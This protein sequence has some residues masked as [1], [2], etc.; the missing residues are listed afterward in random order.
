MGRGLHINSYYFTNRIHYHFRKKVSS[1]R[2]EHLY[3]IPVY[4]GAKKNFNDE[5]IE[6]FNIYNKWDKKFFFS[7]IWKSVLKVRKLFS[8]S[9]FDYIHA[10]TLISDGLVGFFISI[11][12]KKPLVITIRNSDVNFF[13]PNKIFKVL[14]AMVLR[15]ASLVIFL[16][17]SYK[18]RIETLY[19]F[20]VGKQR[21]ILP[22]GLDDFWI[23]NL[24]GENKSHEMNQVVKLL[25]VGKID[26]NKNLNILMNF[27]EN[28]DDRVYEL[29]VVGSNI[30]NVDFKGFNSRLRNKNK[31]VYYG[32]V[33]DKA[34]LLK[35]Y[36]SCDIFVLLSFKET[37][38]ISY[39]EA[40]SQGLPVIYTKNEGIDGYFSDGE[41]GYSCEPNNP[42][43]LTLLIDNIINDY[44]SKS[45]K[46][47]KQAGKFSWDSI[48]D[49]YEKNVNF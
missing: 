13:I 43:M 4:K 24:L 20:T 10:H 9:Q 46:A 16:S 35:I 39:L 12:N 48:I 25:F 15:R 7:K 33:S 34:K 1:L 14:G 3:Y 37:F 36:R 30:N 26:D 47:V 27:L 21:L 28:H 19:P 44:N 5:E 22:N 32:E 38:G 8:S 6:Y 18:F 31:T 49:V 2:D 11:L 45:I 42:E 40:M 23:Q 29:H 41:V 17:P